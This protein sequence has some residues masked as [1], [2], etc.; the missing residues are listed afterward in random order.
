MATSFY[1]NQTDRRMTGANHDVMAGSTIRPS[2]QAHYQLRLDG[3]ASAAV[4]ARGLFIVEA[5]T[6]AGTSAAA[7]ATEAFAS[8]EYRQCRAKVHHKRCYPNSRWGLPSRTAGHVDRPPHRGT[9]FD[10]E[11]VQKRR[12]P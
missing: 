6:R 7:N 5:R 12:K 8:A 10:E 2:R 1:R 3:D 11:H 9:S 4:L